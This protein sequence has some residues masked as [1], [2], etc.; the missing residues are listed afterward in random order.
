MQKYILAH[1]RGEL[2]LVKSS[3]LNGVAVYLALLLAGAALGLLAQYVFGDPVAAF[4]KSPVFIGAVMIVLLIFMLWA[5][6]G[7]FRCG[8]RNLLDCTNKVTSRIGGAAVMIGV[9][10]VAVFV[11]NDLMHPLISSCPMT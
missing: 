8:V 4:F 11:A 7:A 2:G 10:L 6:V 5:L 3:L 1:W 9:V